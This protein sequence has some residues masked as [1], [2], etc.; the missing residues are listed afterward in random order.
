MRSF[1]VVVVDVLFE[2]FLELFFVFKGCSFDQI[3][4]ERSPK[5]FHFS[6][7]LGAI[8]LGVAVF[9]PHFR[10]ESFK[11]MPALFFRFF[12]PEFWTVIRKD[13]LKLDVVIHLQD[14]HYSPNRK[15]HGERL[16][17][18]HHLHPG[19]PGT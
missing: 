1:C 2:L 17:I 9:D 5:P 18:F 11:W 3:F 15:H 14:A 12:R 16:N 6:V 7:G 4:V 13:L 19:D 10:K 8:G